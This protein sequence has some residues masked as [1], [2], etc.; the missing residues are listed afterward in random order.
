MTIGRLMIFGAVSIAI[1]ICALTK[2]APA[3]EMEVIMAGE[4]EYQQHCAVCHGADGKGYGSMRKFLTVEPSDITQTAKKN[5]GRFPFWQIYRII[6]GREEVRG[7]GTREM[8]VWGARFRSQAGGDDTG[9]RSQAA[10]RIL[11]LVF[12]LQ[13]IQE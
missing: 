9:S 3:Q 4:L 12:Y 5:G 13:Q 8:P 6:D 2:L 11:A 1:S 10:G 7:H